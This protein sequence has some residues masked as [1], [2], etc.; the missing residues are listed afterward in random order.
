MED[1]DHEGGASSAPSL[2]T[3]PVIAPGKM[4]ESPSPK[5]N[6]CRRRLFWRRRRRGMA[7]AMVIGTLT[8]KVSSPDELNEDR[9]G[10]GGIE[11]NAR[12]GV[13]GETSHDKIGSAGGEHST[14]RCRGS[15]VAPSASLRRRGRS[16]LGMS[17]AP[18]ADNGTGGDGQDQKQGKERATSHK[19]LLSSGWTD[20]LLAQA[21]GHVGASCTIRAVG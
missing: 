19:T 4:A 9:R 17:A 20:S 6:S 1:I 16:V 8:W 2:R 18:Q 5:V 13:E 14:D 7:R 10:I 12:P 21:R 3:S 15:N 11:G